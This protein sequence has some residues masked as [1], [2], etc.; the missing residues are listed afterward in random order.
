MWTVT[1]KF[2]GE[3][4]IGLLL[5]DFEKTALYIFDSTVPSLQLPRGEQ[6]ISGVDAI[7]FLENI[8]RMASTQRYV[9]PERY[10]WM[11]KYI[12][13]IKDKYEGK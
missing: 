5:Y 8:D 4:H 13:E 12:K 1:D 3:E 7:N 9:N 2:D 11:S 6:V 10:L